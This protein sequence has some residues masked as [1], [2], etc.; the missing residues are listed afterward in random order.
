MSG[1]NEPCPCGSG[2]K[3]KKCCLNKVENPIE[4]WK[5]RAN[6]L[7]SSKELIETFFAVFN[8]A[9]RKKWT[10]ACHTVSSILYVLLCEQGIDAQLRIGYVRS[11]K[12]DATF[13][14]SWITIEDKS[15]D[16]G[17]YRANPISPLHYYTEVSPPI[18][19]GINLESFTDTDVIFGVPTKSEVEAKDRTLQQIMKVSVGEYMRNAPYHKIGIWIEVIEI[20]ER[21]GLQLDYE[22]LKTKYEQIGFQRTVNEIEVSG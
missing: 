5:Q 15:Y 4:V 2:K 3:Y 6:Q 19:K 20:A 9:M 16:V 22:V 14:H 21:L 1:R 10:G 12:F 17:L 13:S 18:F 8:H 7:S 11:Q